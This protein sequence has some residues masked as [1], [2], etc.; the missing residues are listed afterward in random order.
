MEKQQTILV[1]PLDWGLGHAT[2]CVPLIHQFLNQGHRVVLAGQGVSLQ[3]LQQEFPKL[4]AVALKGALIRYSG[5]QNLFLDL[6]LQMPK[7]GFSMVAEHWRLRRLVKVWNITQ[8]VS[9]NR[10]GLWNSKTRNI[11]I[12]HQLFIRLPKSFKWMEFLLHGF[13]RMLISRFDECWVPDFENQEDSLSGELSHGKKRPK[14]LRYIGPLSRFQDF[15]PTEASSSAVEI[16]DVLVL[17]SGPEPFRNRFQQQ[18]ELRFAQST[19]KVLLICGKPGNEL[20]VTG[21]GLRVVSHLP[22]Y[23]LHPLLKHTPKIITLAG[24]STLM[25][26]HAMQRAAE[27]IATPG[28]TE[29][30]YLVEWWKYRN[31]IES[32]K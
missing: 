15:Q 23:E 27:L 28:Q 5:K 22:T 20:R 18:M 7:F 1:A 32:E 2:R 17:V 26:L 21:C 12:T 16:P 8:V 10:Y 24:Y 31:R 29:Q 11:F 9:D 4:P 3:F 13:T 6:F 25:D 19:E 14:N 30:E